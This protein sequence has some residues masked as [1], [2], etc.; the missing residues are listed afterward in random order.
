MTCTTGAIPLARPPHPVGE[1]HRAAA[2][3][4]ALPVPPPAVPCDSRRLRKHPAPPSARRDYSKYDKS[5]RE[6]PHSRATPVWRG[7][8]LLSSA[9]LD[10][11]VRVQL[12]SRS[13][14]HPRSRFAPTRTEPAPSAATSCLTT[15]TSAGS[16][17]HVSD[18]YSSNYS[19]Q[20]A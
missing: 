2:P 15:G 16:G 5:R 14:A 8:G 19:A 17:G 13:V 20:A 18:R 12:E 4:H 11:T 9:I 7:I 6:R 10:S 3:D 1:L